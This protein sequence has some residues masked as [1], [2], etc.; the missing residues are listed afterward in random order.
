SNSTRSATRNRSST[1]RHY[2]NT[3]KVSQSGGQRPRLGIE[4][5][6]K[7]GAVEVVAPHD[8]FPI[9]D[10]K[11]SHDA[12]RHFRATFRADRIGTL[13]HHDS[14]VTHLMVNDYDDIFERVKD[15]PNEIPD[16]VKTGHRWYRDIFVHGVIVKER[17]DGIE[18]SRFPGLQEIAYDGFGIGCCH[19]FNLTPVRTLGQ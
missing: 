7:G 12:Q 9:A 19:G 10:F 5:F 16:L 8:D 15:A 11:D 3:A 2:A 6:L 18:V 13:V 4:H 17:H 1:R 14:A